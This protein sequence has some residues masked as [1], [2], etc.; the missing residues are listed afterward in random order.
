M[1]NVMM[2]SKDIL[3]I[4][5]F[6]RHRQVE[7]YHVCYAQNQHEALQMMGD[8]AID[9]LMLDLEA[10]DTY[11]DFMAEVKKRHPSTI[12]INIVGLNSV[13]DPFDIGQK[14]QAKYV[15]N[16][17]TNLSSVWLTIDK[18]IDLSEKVNNKE[19]L[20]LMA[21][22]EHIPTVPKIYMKLNELIEENAPMDVIAKEIESDPATASNILKLANTAFY[23]AKTGSI[24]QAMMY[25]GLINV[26][27]IILSNAV[28]GND[29]LD[30]ATRDVHWE[31]VRLTNQ[32]L[33]AFYIEVLGKRLDNNLSAV[34][35]LHDI[36]SL[37]LMSNF[38]KAYDTVVKCV[39][40][41]PKL[42]FRDV[43]KELIGFNHELIGGHLLDFWG[44]PYPLIEVAL[45]HH[46]PMAPSVI[47]RELVAA[48]HIAHFYA[49]EL[50]PY[51]KED[52]FFD[53]S[54]YTLLG[55]REE[56]VQR[57]FENF[58]KKQET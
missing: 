4:E 37:V 39:Q 13:S 6:T 28:F 27:N 9:V 50:T 54:V 48:V 53:P 17:S 20:E 26:K 51:K 32:L 1:K 42:N 21:S 25:I 12:R 2:L 44:L 34:G 24:R 7:K 52:N 11:K 23:N 41:N 30:P 47:H 45:M 58:K 46:D 19:L 5:K 36:G 10:I 56:A 14:T 57:F 40:K 33:N 43:E 16:K 22:L 55:T 18:I 35:L 49:W 29:G 8:I 15:C 31:H 3:F 38:P